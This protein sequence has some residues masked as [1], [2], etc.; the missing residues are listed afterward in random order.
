MRLI[1]AACLALLSAGPALAE[2]VNPIVAAQA[3]GNVD[4][5]LAAADATALFENI[6]T[7]DVGVARHR[8]SG[9]V[10]LFTPDDP[11]NLVVVYPARPGGPAAGD[12]VSC[13]TGIGTTFV[14]VYATR[15][16]QQP[17]AEALQAQ[18]AREVLQVWSDVRPLEEGYS[19]TTSNNYPAPL[20]SAFI[21]SL[22]GTRLRSFT[23]V[24]NIGPWSFKGRASGAETDA[25]VTL[26]GSGFYS[27]ALP[28][29]WEEHLRERASD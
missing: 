26:T 21:G 20:T 24:Q 15:Y 10:C 4:A 8:R 13:R 14:T 23:I 25:S 18:A 11:R 27:L 7:D 17:P 9:L 12:D 2:D 5:L 16:P 22:D 29:N 19:I 1:L 3:R 28:G 6:T